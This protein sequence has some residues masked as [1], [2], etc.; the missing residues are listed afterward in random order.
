MSDHQFGLAGCAHLLDEISQL[1][2]GG[3]AGIG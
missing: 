3:N 2:A 1:V